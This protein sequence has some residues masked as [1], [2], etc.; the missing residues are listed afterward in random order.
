VLSR[1]APEVTGGGMAAKQNSDSR[2]LRPLVLSMLAAALLFVAGRSWP[3]TEQRPAAVAPARVVA[4]GVPPRALPA[5]PSAGVAA[6]AVA[7]QPAAVPPL[8]ASVPSAEAASAARPARA[9]KPRQTTPAPHATS[10]AE[11]KS[12][13]SAPAMPRAES[14]PEPSTFEVRQGK[15][16]IVFMRDNPFRR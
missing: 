5:S 3:S 16:T 15:Q 8:D 6:P 13:S 14:K 7:L 9:L 12:A 11:K 2:W 10:Q 4:R 1:A